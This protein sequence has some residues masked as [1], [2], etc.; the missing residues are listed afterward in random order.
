MK[1]KIESIIFASALAVGTI[2]SLFFYKFGML[3]IL[4]D[5]NAHLNISRQLI[6]SM[7][8]GFSQLGLW[9]PLLHIAIAP[10]AQ[11]DFLWK[12]GLA[13]AIPSVI[14]Y[15]ITCVYI[16]KLIKY[17]TK[18]NNMS[19]LGV[20]I[21]ALN[22]YVLYFSSVAMME[23]LFLMNLIIAVFYYARW[24][25]ENNVLHL[26]NFSLFISFAS[27]ARFEGM[28][29]PLIFLVAI[30]LQK[31]IGIIKQQSKKMEATL[32]IFLFLSCLGIFGILLYG[33]TFFGNP[34]A[35]MSGEWSAFA[36]Q[37]QGGFALPAERNLFNAFLYMFFA[38]FYMVGAY[39]IFLS[40]LILPLLL[41]KIRR[42]EIKILFILLAPFL[43]N[44]LSLYRG[45]SVVYIPDLAPFE[46][47]F[48]VRYGLLLVPF[49]VISIPL[50]ISKIK[51][52]IIRLPLIAL[53]LVFSTHFLVSNVSQD[54]FVILKEAGN[55]PGLASKETVRIFEQNYDGGKILI[56]RGLNDFFVRNSGINISDLIQESN[57]L[58]W[59]QGLEK[60]WLFARWIVMLN[61]DSGMI[62]ETKKDE[63]SVKWAND[64]RIDKFYNVVLKNNAYIVLKINENEV[65]NYADRYDLNKE[66]IP[67]LNPEMKKWDVE[68]VDS[69][70]R[71]E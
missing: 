13:G 51:L 25:K 10:F 64:D 28:I 22:P 40:F 20:F 5:E 43:F 66:K 19:L 58:Y 9:P 34:F 41:I 23:I 14:F 31:K 30:L 45:N 69:E 16:Y 29:L 46:R 35:F 71:K 17:I 44:V 12:S 56:V 59:E 62:W 21:F 1:N 11:V 48:N 65:E 61:P 39:L 18:D 50:L 4:V 52:K 6:D 63:I 54:N 32:I 2:A 36:Q 67:S 37:H 70:M 47:F 57:Y 38:S 33:I 26:I 42:I 27:L 3:T 15:A 55:Y 8:P 7:T 53:A 60:P 68:T 24:E 49:I